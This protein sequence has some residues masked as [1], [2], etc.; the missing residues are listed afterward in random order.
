MIFYGIIKK[1]VNQIQILR[2]M[3]ESFQRGLEMKNE[4]TKYVEY[5]FALALKKCGDVNDAEDLTQ[6]TLLAAFQYANR[7][8]T[9]SNMK[10]WLTSVLSNK[11]ND[12]LRKKY[13]LPLVSVDIIPDIEDYEDINDVDRPT[14]EQIRREVAY[15][16]KLQREV[17]VKHYLE[18]KKVQHIADELGV[19]KGTVLSRLS[20]GREQM[21]KGFDSMEQYEKN[22]YVPERLEVGC[23]GNPGFNEE[24]WSLVSDDLMKQNILIIAYEH[25]VTSVEIAKALGIPTPYVE[26]AIEDLVKCELMIRNGNKVVT[27]FLISTPADRSGKLDIQLDF[28]NSQYQVVWNLITELFSEITSLSWFDRFS[29]KAQID[30]KYYAMIDVLARGQYQAIRKIVDTN[31]IYPERPDGGRWIAQGTRYDMD[32]KWENDPFSKY[33]YGGERRANWDNFFS[34]KSVELH[35]YD[36]QPDLNKYE[37]GP[38]EIHDDNLC[39]M[40]YILYKGIPFEYTGFN[41]RYLE[42]IPHLASCGVLRYENDKP[43]VAIPVLSKKEFSELFKIS[44]SYMVK[45]GDLIETPLREL[46]PQLKLEIPAHLEGRIAEFR[47]YVFYAFPMSIIKKAIEIGDFLLDEHQKAIPMVLVIEESDNVVR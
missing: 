29:N 45:L 36:T 18:G 22:S 34:S 11:W 46:F 5:L 41:L 21:R 4:I 12:M 17:I 9:V 42:D 37:H 38:V 20:S 31:E 2:L 19:P 44:A 25:P 13:R 1:Q 14:A 3:G 15:L 35:V 32:F 40:L 43:Q 10:Y 26:N 27:D 47:K 7:G 28:A 23:S 30:L 24:P 33:A 39:K 16:A 6:E 8:G